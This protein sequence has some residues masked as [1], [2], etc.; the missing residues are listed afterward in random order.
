MKPIFAKIIACGAAA[1]AVCAGGVW[2]ALAYRAGGGFTPGTGAPA[3]QNNQLLFPESNAA[4]SENGDQP[5]EKDSFWQQDEAGK[6]QVGQGENGGYLFD[7]VQQTDS[8]Y[9]VNTAQGAAGAG[10]ADIVYD[11]VNGGKADAVI[12]GSAGQG[13][14]GTANGSGSTGS[15]PVP[16]ATPAPAPEPETPAAP[17]PGSYDPEPAEKQ[18]TSGGGLQVLPYSEKAAAQYTQPPTVSVQDRGFGACAFL[19]GGQTI[20]EKTVFSALNAEVIFDKQSGVIYY[21][22]FEDLGEN[23][24]IKID[25]I[26]FDDGEVWLS[27]TRG[28][29]IFPAEIP[30]QLPSK[31]LQIKVSYRLKKTDGWTRYTANGSDS[32]CCAISDSRVFVLN[33]RLEA[34]DI[35]LENSWILNADEG[36]QYPDIGGTLLLYRWQKD[37]L[38][39]YAPNKSDK[40]DKLFPGWEE[41]GQPVGWNYVV[42]TPGR[43]ILQ[44]AEPVQIDTEQYTVEIKQFTLTDGQTAAG[45]TTYAQPRAASYSVALQTLTGASGTAD[46]EECKI[47]ENVQAVQ[48]NTPGEG[49][50]AQTIEIPRSVVVIDEDSMLSESGKLQAQ[51]A[52]EVDPENPCYDT[53]QSG[54][55][56]NKAQTAYLG[57]P[58]SSKELSVP[59]QV[60]RVLFTE[61]NQLEKITLQSEQE[62]PALQ[63]VKS[64][65]KQCQLETETLQQMLQLAHDYTAEL[66][67]NGNRVDHAQNQ[68]GTGYRVNLYGLTAGDED[69]QLFRAF[70]TGSSYTI[71]EG[72]T[73]IAAGAFSD[74]SCSAVETLVL[75]PEA[76]P[77]ML[78]KDLFADGKIKNI[79]CANEEQA[80]AM[81]QQLESLGLQNTV[82]ALEAQNSAEG[83]WYQKV[84]G[85]VTLLSVPK[86]IVFF[87]GTI[88]LSDGTSLQLNAI[89]DGAFEGCEQLRVAVLPES[90][91]KIGS[92]AFAGC[93]SLE[94]LLIQ[95]KDTITF[96]EDCLKGCDNLR[97][98]ASN[99]HSGVMENGYDPIVTDEATGYYYMYAPQ[100]CEGYNNHWT[101][102][103]YL[104]MQGYALQKLGDTGYAVYGCSDDHGSWALLRTTKTLDPQFTL[105]EGTAAI[106]PGAMAYADSAQGGF[107]IQNLGSLQDIILENYA[108]AGSGLQGAVQLPKLCGLGDA[109]FANCKN[110]T[111]LHFGE[112]EEGTALGAGLCN[113]CDSLQQITFT[114]EQPPRLT[115][116]SPGIEF[117]F[118]MEWPQNAAEEVKL[119]LSVPEGSEENYISQWRY[120]VLGYVDTQDKGRYMYARRQILDELIWGSLGDTHTSDAVDAKLE[121]KLL[122]AENYLRT[123]LGM[124]AVDEASEVYHFRIAGT[125]AGAYLLAKTT[126]GLSQADLRDPAKLGLLK[127]DKIYYLGE[128]AFARSLWLQEVWLPNELEGIFNTPFA[129]DEVWAQQGNTI[130]VTVGENIP[131]L[132]GFSDGTAFSFGVPDECLCL[133]VSESQQQALLEKWAPPLTGYATREKL[134]AAV[135][136]QLGTSATQQQ[137]EAAVSER[138]LQAENRLRAM[139]G[140]QP[141]TPEEASQA[142]QSDAAQQEDDSTV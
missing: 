118:N 79:L 81:K 80:A 131:E 51:N 42:S 125:L 121:E 50:T 76:E 69:E 61:D 3:M 110:L 48:I 29:A 6:N 56:T 40:L 135:A 136:A 122:R 139:M 33:K 101:S 57:I 68:Q 99:A 75:S 31:Q 104:Y 74:E 43:H 54:I 128:N 39:G 59:E 126:P 53:D 88:T 20:T 124:D 15:G 140:L 55:L 14:G 63:G 133:Q 85:T 82:Q 84:N 26:S 92:R 58:L 78:Q 141:E 115:L 64:L 114:D 129:M 95:S 98:V 138:M 52:F 107:A 102:T 132:M 66:A 89:G 21:W 127:T 1:A 90:V 35:S 18:P 12:S 41:N 28:E 46:A 67:K 8:T 72:I 23:G 109:V 100:G 87:D 113:G 112:V 22:T 60:E 70:A 25:D 86:D 83:Y 94:I 13:T 32:I 11:I 111:A 2:L 16:A 73:K 45:Q 24:Y 116:F 65:Q 62:L 47:P 71:P 97:I 5:G 4:A 34:Q 19:Y 38:K 30:Q 137:I 134:W 119:H 77:E 123:M 37:I 103:K 93:K 106:L 9:T 108:F 142:S 49:L 117:R 10:S 27:Q 44:P 91:K 7:R 17:L 105:P 130:T 36:D 96:G 120:A